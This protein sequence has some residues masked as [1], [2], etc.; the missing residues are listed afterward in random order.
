VTRTDVRLT[1]A[2]A[3]LLLAFSGAAMAQQFYGTITGTVSDPSGAVVP[4]ATIK[5]IN[6]DTNVTVVLK[7]N[8]AGVY[9]ANN[10]IV[11]TYRVEAEAVGFKRAIASRIPLE[12]GATPK[13]D[14]ELAVGQTN[15]S[16]TVTEAN[17]P[18]LQTQ[19]T[20]LGQTV[21]SSRLEQLP[22]FSNSGRRP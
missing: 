11:G 2:V 9:V 1:I 13:L 17:S 5:V 8:A 6:V 15:E 4:N 3:A 10:L 7:T 22:T 12:V 19:Q 14:L 16:V 20:D 18:I 21:D